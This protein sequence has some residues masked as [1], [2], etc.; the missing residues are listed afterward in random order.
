VSTVYLIRHAAAG[1]R[2]RWSGD[3]ALRPLSSRGRAQAEGL[4]DVI[5]AAGPPPERLLSS[6]A[7]RCRQTLAP[8]SAVLRVEIEEHPGLAEGN[9]NGIAA[10]IGTFRSGAV[11][12]LCTHG[13]VIDA[14]LGDVGTGAVDHAPTSEKG[15]TWILDVASEIRP[16]GYSPPPKTRDRER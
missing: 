2:H 9:G 6:P 4:T 14:L 1:N 13:D 10:F 11:V 15:G 5:W 8:L 16:V 3:D 7:V 12:A